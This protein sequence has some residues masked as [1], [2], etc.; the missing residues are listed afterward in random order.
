MATEPRA[1]EVV[2]K[3]SN[4]GVSYSTPK[5][6]VPPR[7]MSPCGTGVAVGSAA[8]VVAVAPPVVAVAAPPLVV[9]VAAPVAAVGV[10]PPVPV[11]AAVV[12][13][14]VAAVVGALVAAALV[15]VALSLPPQ[16]ARR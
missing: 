4:T 11:V 12:G 16:A 8:A 7:G 13:A 10:G 6:S 5:L 15:L 1:D 9:A 2:R 14:V 3:G